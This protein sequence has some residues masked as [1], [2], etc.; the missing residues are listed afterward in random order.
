MDLNL[1][2]LGE[3]KP[4]LLRAVADELKT[5]ELKQCFY[6]TL[7]GDL[8]ETPINRVTMAFRYTPESLR[9]SVSKHWEELTGESTA[10]AFSQATQRADRVQFVAESTKAYSPSYPIMAI[11]LLTVFVSAYG[12]TRIY[13]KQS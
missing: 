8:L 2:Y 10:E 6:R 4:D 11:G 1:S 5:G 7:T 12:V 9:E 3:K 13:D